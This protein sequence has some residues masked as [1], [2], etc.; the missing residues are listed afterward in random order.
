MMLLTMCQLSQRLRGVSMD[1][2]RDNGSPVL[3][4]RS[5]ILQV[6]QS[7]RELLL[8]QNLQFSFKSQFRSCIL[9]CYLWSGFHPSGR[10][11]FFLPHFQKRNTNG[12]CKLMYIFIHYCTLPVKQLVALK[13]ALILA[14]SRRIESLNCSNSPNLKPGAFCPKS[15]IHT[16]STQ[17][18]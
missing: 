12:K 8:V 11:K 7:S 17:V 5:H 10:Q 9:S 16:N 4:Q 18:C 6:K 2:L 14:F 15:S 3:L 13:T 1:G